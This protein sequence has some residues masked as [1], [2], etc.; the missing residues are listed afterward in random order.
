MTLGDASPHPLS[1]EAG[2]GIW[3]SLSRYSVK[4]SSK[5]KKSTRFPRLVDYQNP[6]E[7]DA[8]RRVFEACKSL[9]GDC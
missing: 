1:A 3:I 7:N 6:I 9:R 8:P 2:I 4:H 5:N